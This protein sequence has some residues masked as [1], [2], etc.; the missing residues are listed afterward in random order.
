M[1]KRKKTI[2]HL[3]LKASY[4]SRASIE[5]AH[6]GERGLHRYMK[7]ECGSLFYMST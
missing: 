6:M 1:M 7:E 5:S 4:M 2:L 3:I